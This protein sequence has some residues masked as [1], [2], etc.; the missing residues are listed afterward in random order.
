MATSRAG[1]DV[2]ESSGFLSALPRAAAETLLASARNRTVNCRDYGVR[3]GDP[4]MG[5]LWLHSGLLY[6]FFE[7]PDGS[8]HAHRIGWPHEVSAVGVLEDSEYPSSCVALIPSE[9][10]WVP[11]D[12]VQRAIHEVGDLAYALFCHMARQEERLAVWSSHLLSLPVGDRIR[13]IL[14]RIALEMGQPHGGGWLLDFPLTNGTLSTVAHVSRDETGRAVRR[15]V[16]EGL[17]ERLPGRRFVVPAIDRLLEPN[18]QELAA[19]VGLH[20]PSA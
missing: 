20:L 9:F 2:I 19:R 15:L 5:L 13:L 12:V 17:V 18:L 6:V 4:S 16:S 10:L 1:D 3:Q 8:S 14:G 7:L 11:R